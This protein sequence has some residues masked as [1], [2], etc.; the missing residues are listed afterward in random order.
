MNDLFRNHVDTITAAVHSLHVN[1]DHEQISNIY[2]H[3]T[4]PAAARLPR[5]VKIPLK[6]KCSFPTR[7]IRLEFDHTTVG[8]YIEIDTI[9]LCG[10]TSKCN[11][12]LPTV[13]FNR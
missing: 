7:Y 9:L 10:Q 1:S 12:P 11:L 2:T 6:N 4:Y 8:Y 13:S 3:H 5:I